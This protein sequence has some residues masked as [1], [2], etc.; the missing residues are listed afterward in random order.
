MTMGMGAGYWAY[1]TPTVAWEF[2][3]N[4]ASANAD[5]CLSARLAQ[6][7]LDS[8]LDWFLPVTLL[9]DAFSEVIALP[10]TVLN[11]EGATESSCHRLRPTV[12]WS[13]FLLCAPD[14]S[15]LADSERK[16]HD[17]ESAD[18]AHRSD[19]HA[20]RCRQLQ[21]PGQPGP[22]AHDEL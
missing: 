17:F 14:F 13:T 20:A 4:G 22:G 10:G 2:E 11:A 1:Y 16:T 12:R 21:G 18:E 19:A 5:A 15:S 6:A 9:G 8:V 7:A 3:E